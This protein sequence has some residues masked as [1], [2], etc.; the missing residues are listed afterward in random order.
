[1]HVSISYLIEFSNEQWDE[2]KIEKTFN[3]SG[4]NYMQ[5]KAILFIL[6]LVLNNI[7][8]LLNCA[9]IRYLHGFKKHSNICSDA[10]SLHKSFKFKKQRK[11]LIFSNFDNK[12]HEIIESKFRCFDIF[13]L[14]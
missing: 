4:Q 7:V 8:T 6:I 9:T 12:T 5:L 3:S 1:M 2:N 13:S 11:S 14:F 10:N